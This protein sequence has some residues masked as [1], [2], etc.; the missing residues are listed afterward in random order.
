MTFVVYVDDASIVK[1]AQLRAEALIEKHPA[2]LVLVDFSTSKATP[3]EL[4]STTHAQIVPDVPTVLFWAGK[5]SVRDPNFFALNE[6][7]D[8]LVL[9]SSRGSGDIESLRQLIEYF[10]Q[11]RRSKVQD[12]A[13]LRLAPWQ[14]MIATFFD[15]VELAPDLGKIES[16]EIVAGSP[17]EQYYLLGW[18]ASRLSWKPDMVKFVLRSKGEP[19]R[20]YDV[21]LTSA[22]STYRACLEEC[23]GRVVCLTVEGSHARERHCETLHD[24]S[25]VA[26]VEQAILRPGTSDVFRATLDAAHAFLDHAAE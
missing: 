11:G 10:A 13:Y 22:D 5:E 2:R 16:V 24:V 12:L 4:K 18:L 6:L 1:E 15:D 19:R 3:E 7:A 8:I 14:E 21:A 17:A 9:D 20:V 26:L 23:K 25:I